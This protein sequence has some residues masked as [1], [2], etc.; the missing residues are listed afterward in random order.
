MPPNH[1]TYFHRF[2]ENMQIFSSFIFI[3]LRAINKS[4]YLISADQS[5]HALET[6]KQSPSCHKLLEMLII[7]IF[8]STDDRSSA[9]AA[10]YHGF[11]ITLI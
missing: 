8:C 11:C 10:R 6:I 7:K 5:D 2:V 1:F 4:E 3:L 9:A